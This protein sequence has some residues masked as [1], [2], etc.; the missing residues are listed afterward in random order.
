MWIQKVA[1][2]SGRPSER[3]PVHQK[4]STQPGLFVFLTY[5]HS[6]VRRAR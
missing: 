6:T 3:H 4:S 2:A 5:P 1:D